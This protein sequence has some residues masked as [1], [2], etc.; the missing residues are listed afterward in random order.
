MSGNSLNSPDIFKRVR[1]TGCDVKFIFNQDSKRREIEAH[2]IILALGSEVFRAQFFGSI[3]QSDQVEIEQ[4]SY[5]SFKIFI[6]TFYNSVNLGKYRMRIL[7]DLYCLSDYYS[8]PELQTASMNVLRK[9]SF[10]NQDIAEAAHIATVAKDP[11][12][13]L[14]E[15]L[16]E[17]VLSTCGT[18]PER[19][20]RFLGQHRHLYDNSVKYSDLLESVLDVAYKKVKRCRNCQKKY[21]NCKTQPFVS[22]NNFVPGASVRTTSD[23]DDVSSLVYKLGQLNSDLTFTSFDRFGFDLPVMPLTQRGYKYHC[24]Q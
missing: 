7:S 21:F 22:Q 6:D 8:V 15:A 13:A 18:D 20:K 23:S 24:D 2:K 3:S 17:R 10:S 14:A 9:A 16:F 4:W 1:N 5:K 11:Y 12:P 19:I